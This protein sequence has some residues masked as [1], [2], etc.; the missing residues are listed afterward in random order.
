MVRYPVARELVVGERPQEIVAAAGESTVGGVYQLAD[1]Y[2]V[3]H[4]VGGIG[5]LDGLG[6]PGQPVGWWDSV[7]RAGRIGG[8]GRVAVRQQLLC[9]PAV[10]EFLALAQASQALAEAIAGLPVPWHHVRPLRL[11]GD[12]PGRAGCGG[13][14]GGERW[15][16]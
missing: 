3:G 15:A 13:D 10:I 16:K 9:E 11:R 12:C 5:L 6:A 4:V 14:G 7:R 8:I 1:V 2:I